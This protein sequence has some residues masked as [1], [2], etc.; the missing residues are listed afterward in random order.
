MDQ[1]GNGTYENEVTL[2]NL[3]TNVILT[4]TV[5]KGK[6]VTAQTNWWYSTAQ[7]HFWEQ[8]GVLGPLI[9]FNSTTPEHVVNA[10][11]WIRAQYAGTDTTVAPA[12]DPGDTASWFVELDI[13]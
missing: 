6:P 5:P 11:K 3:E 13:A 9:A 8:S 12:Q 7:Q 2:E 10:E 1:S 4:A